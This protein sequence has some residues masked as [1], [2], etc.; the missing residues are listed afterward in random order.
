[1]R[2]RA[3]FWLA[4]SLA[5]LSV[6]LYVAGIVFAVLTL[7]VADPVV[8]PSSTWGTGGTIGELVVF[9]PFLA[10]PIVGGLIASKRPRNPI[11][12]ICLV[13]GLFWMSSVEGDQATAYDLARTGQ[14]LTP[15]MVEAWGQS[16]WVLPVGLQGAFMIMLF[17]DGRLPS[18]R[19]RPLAYIAGAAILLASI[20]LDLEPGPL[21]GRSGVRNP[22]GIEGQSWILAVEAGCL[23]VLAACILASAASLIFRYRH[24]DREVRQ[25]IKWLAF[26]ASFVGVTY[27]TVL[28]SG[29]FFSP[30]STFDQNRTPVWMSLLQNVV[31]ISYAGIPTAIGFAVLKYRLYDIDLLINRTLV[32][33]SLTV[34]LAGIYFGSVVGIQAAFRAFTGQEQQPQLAVVVSTLAIAALFG[35]LRR[36]IQ[37]V[38]DRRFYRR[39][40]DRARIM[41]AFGA[42]LREEVELQTLS[43]DL[44]EVLQE[45][46]QPAHASLWLRSPGVKPGAKE[47]DP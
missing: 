40:Y 5:G 30:E 3:A 6:A 46:V 39:K 27:L 7:G 15:V 37:N 33:G 14:V 2:R 35:P 19:W 43:N 18:R 36:R 32:Y 8:P 11:G 42:R 44:L 9:L 22:L 13:A 21:P 20:A 24:S 47:R 1:M 23:L 12:W 4:W 31:L 38:I 17:P 34:T 25:Q 41:A 10:F 45:T 29:I 26:A 16:L 28:V